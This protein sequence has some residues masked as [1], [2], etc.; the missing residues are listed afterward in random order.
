M[1]EVKITNKWAARIMANGK[2]IFLG[3]FKKTVDAAKAYNDAAIKYH[4]EF[5]FLNKI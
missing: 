5:A 4:G 3:L 2:R 1:S